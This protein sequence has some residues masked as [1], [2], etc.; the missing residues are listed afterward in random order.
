MREPK[1]LLM[2]KTLP[3]GGQMR[4]E[5]CS[6]DKSMLLNNG[7]R[8]YSGYC[9]RCRDPLFEAHG[10]HSLATLA[11]R[12]AELAMVQSKTVELPRD[13]TLSIPPAE[14][15]W[16]YKAGIGGDM[17]AHYGIGYSP[18]MQRV[19]FPVYED[20]QLTAFTARL[21]NGRPKYIEKS[22]DPSGTVFVASSSKLL[23]TYKDWAAGSG[24]DCVLVEDN[25]SAVR[26]GRVVKRCVSLMG[27]S[28][29]DV[30]LGKALRPR[31]VPI[32]TVAIWLDPDKP[33]RAAS[34]RLHG[35]LRMQGYAA[36]EIVTARDPKYYSNADIKEILSL[37]T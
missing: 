21:Q 19:V 14:A 17:I 27:T 30:Q 26:V 11:R 25:L 7:N 33:G 15:V 32:L 37:S 22:L 8:G 2:A 20:G 5:C 23:A 6:A 9:F 13:F 4:I 35:A 1:W 34:R 18:F 29:S 10:E 24:P 3:A 31:G 16:L 12:Q 36:V 28:F